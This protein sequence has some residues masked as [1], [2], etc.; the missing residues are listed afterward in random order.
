MTPWQTLARTTVLQTGRFLTVEMHSVGLPD[1]RIIHQWPWLVTPDFSIVVGQTTDGRFLCFRQTQYAVE[2]TSLAPAG[3]YLEP[4]EE[5]L[6]A[7][8]R[9]FLEETGHTAAE[10]LPLGTYAVDANRGAG[11]AHLFLA[12]GCRCVAQPTAHDL[13][14]QHLL[15]LSRAEVEKSLI[16]GEFKVLP[17]AAAFALALARLAQK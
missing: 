16:D 10:W 3:G 17:W 15:F 12:R 14:E 2:G 4:G 8:Q 5:P 9:E 7:A 13:E 1:G 6:A 11:R